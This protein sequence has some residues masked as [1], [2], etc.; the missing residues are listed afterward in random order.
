[1]DRL[2]PLTSAHLYFKGIN[3]V[4]P[5]EG[6]AV[7]VA[8]VDCEYPWKRLTPPS[9]NI[10]K[11]Y[12]LTWLAEAAPRGVRLLSVFDLGYIDVALTKD[13]NRSR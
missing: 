5:L 11:C 6:W 10:L 12:L 3:T 7:P 4:V 2:Y 8:W 9:Q 13:L 1:M